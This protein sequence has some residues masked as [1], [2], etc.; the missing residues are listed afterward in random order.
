MQTT[1]SDESR[2]KTWIDKDG[3]IQK[4]QDGYFATTTPGSGLFS[5]KR[6]PLEFSSHRTFFTPQE[7]IAFMKSPDKIVGYQN[8]VR[9]SDG[10][11]HFLPVHRHELGD[12]IADV[13]GFKGHEESIVVHHKHSKIESV[14]FRGYDFVVTPK[15]TKREYAKIIKT[16]PDWEIEFRPAKY[17]KIPS[18]KPKDGDAFDVQ[19]GSTV[20]KT[21]FT[22]GNGSPQQQIA[23]ISEK[24][25]LKPVPHQKQFSPWLA[26]L[27]FFLPVGFITRQ[28]ITL[29]RH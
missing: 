2:V 7:V 23:K 20:H 19:V 13:Y 24:P 4:R 17:E 21:T 8:F 18:L 9:S 6:L 14:K 15:F 28:L 12:E 1:S 10:Q 22:A 5:G 11:D 29:R 26:G 16:K 25:I 27:V 3:K